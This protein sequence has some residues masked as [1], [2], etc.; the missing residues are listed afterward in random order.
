MKTQDVNEIWDGEHYMNQ[1]LVIPKN[2][3]IIVY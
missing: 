1:A 3:H 2:L